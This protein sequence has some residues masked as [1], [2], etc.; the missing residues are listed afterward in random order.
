MVPANRGQVVSRIAVTI[1]PGTAPLVDAVGPAAAAVERARLAERIAGLAKD[2]AAFAKDA[3]ADPA[4]VARKKQELADARARDAKLAAD[5]MRAPAGG[6][7]FTLAQVGIARK[8]ACDASVQQAKVAYNEAAG[9]ANL[10]A[11]KARPPAPVPPGTATYVGAEECSNCH[12]K[13]Y[14]FW[15]KTRHAKAWK[16]LE[17]TGKQYDY[18][19]TGCHVTGFGE[20]GGS[21]MAKT[22]G[23]RDVQCEVC[24]GP[25]SIH[26]EKEGEE[27]PLAIVREP[28][29]DLCATRCHTPEHSDTFQ[30]EAYLRD[31]TGPG[32]GGKARKALGDGPT[33]H[34]LRAAGLARAGKGVGAGMREVS[35][36]AAAALAVALGLG[37]C[38][39][40]GVADP[41]GRAGFAARRRA[42]A[43]ATRERRAPPGHRATPARARSCTAWPPGTAAPSTAGK[44]ASGERFDKR[45][46]TAAH[47]TLPFGT[48]VRVT[49]DGNHRSVT[50]RINDRGPFGHDR[51]RIIDL[52][53]AAARK[54][55]M[56]GAGVARVTIEVLSRAGPPMSDA[57]IELADVHKRFGTVHALRGAEVAIDGRITGLLG[58]NGAGKSTLIKCLLGLID[59]EGERRGPR[60]V[61]PRRRPGDPRPGRLHAG[62][63]RLPA[64]HVGGRAVRLRRRA[65]G[66][67]PDRGDAAGPRRAVLRRARGQAL[68]AD[69]RLLDRHEAAGQAGRRRWST[70][71]S[72]C[73]STSRPT[74]STRGRA[75]RCSS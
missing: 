42:R 34:E 3:S 16:T 72:C 43:R 35:P 67:A 66:P 70:T 17:D 46:L 75:R 38:G 57:L 8:L 5:P 54:L 13:E 52:S 30:H 26:V 23:L 28:A 32:H 33:G 41:A 9:Q 7:Y 19:C 39:R 18:E 36:A 29:A 48:I 12:G 27:K 50:V 37:A 22:D 25:G 21:T 65:V 74:A 69:R 14:A 53:E 62:E 47:R 55:D 60:P 64:G 2:L 10:E 31:V 45:K 63:R 49:R 71:P 68:P 11:A 44:T 15:K 58:P 40:P 51:R 73:S 4:F 1:R 6:S 61:G 20:P 59:F 56:I 24:H